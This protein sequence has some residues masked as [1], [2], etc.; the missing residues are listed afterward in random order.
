MPSSPVVGPGRHPRATGGGGGR[1]ARRRLCDYHHRRSSRRGGR[2][3]DDASRANTRL[4]IVGSE[5]QGVRERVRRDQERVV[6]GEGGGGWRRL[7]S[8]GSGRREDRL[9]EAG[10]DDPAAQRLRQG[11]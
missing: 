10:D 9:A 1:S 6:P 5:A 8:G 11:E 7:R 3:G 4:P 2:D